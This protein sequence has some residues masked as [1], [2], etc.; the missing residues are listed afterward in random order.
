MR[1]YGNK[2]NSI[3]ILIFVISLWKAT[4]IYAEV[5]TN[6]S[7]D[8][9]IGQPDF[10]SSS[11]GTS[12]RDLDTPV[13]VFIGYDKLIVCEFGNNRILIWNTI[14]TQNYQPADVVIGQPDF[15]TSS[16]GVTQ[17]KIYLPNSVFYDGQRLY[18]GSWYNRRVLIWNSLPTENFTP[19]D[20]VLGQPDFTTRTIGTTQSKMGAVTDVVTDGKKLFVVD[21]GNNR[22]LIYNSI[23]TSNFAPADIVLGQPDFTTSSSGT[24]S[25]QLNVP[26]DICYDGK[27]LFLSE[28]NNNRVLV[29]NSLP[30]NNNAPADIVVGQPDFTTKSSA[31]GPAKTGSVSDV[32]SDGKLLFVADRTNSRILIYK[33][34]PTSNGAPADIV[35]GQ[36]DF[37]TVNTDVNARR[38]DCDGISFDG[39]RLAVVD[40]NRNRVLIFN[41][42]GSSIDLGPQFEQGK[43]VLG[44]VFNDINKDGRQSKDELGIEGVKVVSDTG[45]YAITDEDGKYH[46]PYIEVGQHVL[47]I[48]ESTLPDGSILTTDSPRKITVTKGIL[49]KVSF[50][51]ELPPEAQPIDQ[52]TTQGPLLKVSI[53]QDPV[54][55][56][57]RL[58][59]AAEQID[60][61]IIFTIDC[62]Y[63]LFIERADLYIY[64]ESYNKIETIPLGKP[65][66]STYKMEA[67][68]LPYGKNYYYQLSV[69]DKD[70]NENRTGIGTL[71][72][73]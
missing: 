16:G 51:V 55:L 34:I 25:N 30:Q 65:L 7:A 54:L 29:W 9:V 10:T 13:E 43:A 8:V 24:T 5:Y 2:I 71:R 46:F 50:G 58:Q 27:Q 44:K 62:N 69:Y 72:I 56:K 66:P 59:L 64:D 26:N 21:Q 23:P 20:I 37:S 52:S 19:A 41:I 28:W 14:P 57:P 39:K 45:I 70:N 68:D 48:D 17:S 3:A 40:R 61:N 60:D 11:A 49:T 47:K 22:V 18:M 42:S 53:S 73:K 35:L 33:S 1:Y 15:T 6:M 63:F 31:V 4:N 38:F 32:Y 12:Q 36:E 67:S